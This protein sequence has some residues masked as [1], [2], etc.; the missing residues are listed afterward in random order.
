MNIQQAKFGLHLR[1]PYTVDDIVSKCTLV[2]VKL[3]NWFQGVLR[4]H[5]Y[6]V[7]SS[8]EVAKAVADLTRFGGEAA[9]R[10]KQHNLD[11]TTAMTLL[12]IAHRWGVICAY[13][14]NIIPPPDFFEKLVK[15]N[16]VAYACFLVVQHYGKSAI[17]LTLERPMIV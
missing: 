6:D 7:G 15:C 14:R 16:R 4:D 10:L 8:D 5:P 2:C 12:N 9:V 1:E 13:Y 17:H 3:P 11:A